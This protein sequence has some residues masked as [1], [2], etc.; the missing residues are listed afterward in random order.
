MHYI[1]Y[2]YCMSICNQVCYL[3]A[4]LHTL[5]TSISKSTTIF[6]PYIL[7]LSYLLTYIIQIL[8]YLYICNIYISI[9]RYLFSPYSHNQGPASQSSSSVT[10]RSAATFDDFDVITSLAAQHI[11]K[12]Y[13]H[14]Y[15]TRLADS[16]KSA[17]EKSGK[18]IQI[19]VFCQEMA[20]NHLNFD[21]RR[22]CTRCF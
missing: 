9:Q 12:K 10:Q 5:S 14:I 16:S 19:Q 15:S 11:I 21:F 3:H 20:K 7:H 13:K 18:S 17:Y 8:S 22:R 1:I 4:Y 2:L 6:I